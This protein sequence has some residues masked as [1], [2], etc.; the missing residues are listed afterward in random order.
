MT[1]Q[2][3]ALRRLIADIDASPSPCDRQPPSL[4][5]RTPSLQLMSIIWLQ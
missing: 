2:I 5:I 3:E 1:D 4:S